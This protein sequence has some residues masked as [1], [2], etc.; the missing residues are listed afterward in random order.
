M[1]SKIEPTLPH[2]GPV[3]RNHANRL[4]HHVWPRRTAACLAVLAYTALLSSQAHANCTTASNATLCDSSA[5]SPWTTTIGAGPNTAPGASATVGS[6][7]QVVV[8]D[9]SAIALGDQA[10]IAV[11]SGALVQNKAVSNK[12]AYGTGANTI[13]FGSNSTLTVEQGATV[14]SSGTEGNGEAV[15]P[16]GTGNTIVNDGTIRAMHAAAIWFQTKT[17]SNTVVNNATGVI[18]TDVANGNVLGSSGN[19]AVDFTNRGKVVGNLVFAGGDDTLH[20]YNGS[21]VSGSID[22]GAGNNLITLNGSGSDTLPIITRFQTLQKQDDGTWTVANSL[23]GMGVTSTEV[24]QGTLVLTGDNS[25]YAGSMLVDAGG[26]LQSSAQ[27]MPLTVTDNGLVRFQQDAD[28]TYSGSISGSGAVDKN[29]TGTLTLDGANTYAGGTTVSEGTL[30]VGDPNTPNASITGPTSVASGA[31]LGG[32]GSVNGDVSNNGTLA[33][34]NALA[35][36]AGDANGSFV[37]HGRL[38]NAGTVQLG[39][40]QTVGNTLTVSSYVGNN[41]I[42]ALNT[43]LAG[44][45][46]ASDKLVVDG[47]T[48]TGSTTLKIT[49]VGGQGAAI[50]S[51]GILVVQATNGATTEAG[52]FTLAGGTMKAGAYEYY[53]VRGGVTTGTSEDWYLRNTLPTP[54]PTPAP[55]PAPAPTPAPTPTPTPAPTPTPTPAPAPSK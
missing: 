42:L 8:G 52:A 4:P 25:A 49:N 3:A 47:G 12:G 38:T 33:V 55:S 6:N 14:L 1:H 29:G 5:P 44:D 15:N 2:G 24:Q 54:A 46:A 17:G 13:D 10:T 37:V 39:G 16:E 34:A 18:E 40:G 27:S 32:Y 45:N 26:T 21:S 53:L 28:G 19:A 35:P 22:G 36:F 7:A 30:V 48:A 50:M 9:A 51:N 23:S 41:G 11:Q 43:V 20:L 31:V